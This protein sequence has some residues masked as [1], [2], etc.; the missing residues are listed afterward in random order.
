[1][2]INLHLLMPFVTFIVQID[3]RVLILMIYDNN[4][5]TYLIDYLNDKQMLMKNM[6]VNLL[7]LNLHI[8]IK[9]L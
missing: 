2:V 5:L 3:Y 6:F 4:K 7:D 9:I 8:A 1:M